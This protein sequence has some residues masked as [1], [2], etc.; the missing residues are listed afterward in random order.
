ME[1]TL[2]IF[3][4]SLSL[5]WVMGFGYLMWSREQLLVL[6]Q[7]SASMPARW[8]LFS[9]VIPACNEAANLESAVST[10]MRQD[11]P[12]L[13]IILV[14]DRST[15]GTGEVIDRL[16]GGDSRIR[17]VH[18]RA[19]PE[20][21]LGKVHALQKGVEIARGEWLLFTDADVHFSPGALRRAVALAIQQGAD[22]LTLIPRT[23]QSGF[24]LDVAVRAFSLLFF[25][26]TRAASVNRPGSKAFVGIGAFNLV[27]AQVFRRTAGFEW[28]RLEPGD[29]VGLGMM[30]KRAGGTSRIAIAYDDLYVRWYDSVP[31]M[32]KGLEKNLFGPASHYRWWLMILQVAMIWALAAAPVVSLIGGAALGSASL[33]IA[34]GA[35]MGM[36]IFFALFYYFESPAEIPSLLLFP[37]GMLLITLMMLRAGFQCIWNDGID[38]RGTHYPLDQLRAG[39]RVK[40]L[41][42][43]EKL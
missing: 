35:A 10:L 3:C 21:W 14:D 22:H 11:Y 24:W 12:H 43:V 8:P 17:A 34:G 1:V 39:Q 32:F 4:L 5:L 42:S 30:I 37:A 23:M 16:A 2:E 20:G 38:W 29:D 31:A 28:L 13:E 33:L 18:V 19:L 15:D 27:R 25:L 7:E 40:F 36:H 9:I 6:N 26:T 41:R